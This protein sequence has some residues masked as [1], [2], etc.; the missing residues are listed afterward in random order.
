MVNKNFIATGKI[1]PKIAG[2]FRKVIVATI[3]GFMQAIVVG[4]LSMLSP[5]DKIHL[6]TGRTGYLGRQCGIDKWHR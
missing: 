2:G 6:A 5:F 1:V 3:S 4:E